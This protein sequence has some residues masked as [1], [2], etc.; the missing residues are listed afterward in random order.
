M[1]AVP[2]FLDRRTLEFLLFEVH[3]AAS[4]CTRDRFVDYDRADF[5]AMLSIARDMSAAQFAPH[6]ARG[7][8]EEPN[9]GDDGTVVLPPEVKP[10]LDAFIEAGFMASTFDAAHGGLQLPYLVTLGY[11]SFFYSAN[12]GT[13]AYAGLTMAAANLLQTFGTP[14][15]QRFTGAMI[16]GRMFG[17][18]CLS[19]PHAG[20]S[21]GNT[22]CKAIPRDDGRYA[23][24]GDKM[25]I[26]GGEHELSENIGHL[27]LARMPDAPAGTRGIS[28]FIVPRY[29]IDED[30][31]S[32][33]VDN[34]VR[35]TGI[36]HK[37]GS[38][39]TINCVMTFG[40][41][42]ES[43]GELVGE[44]NR[45]LKLMFMMMNEARI[46]VGLVAAV[47]GIA[48]HRNS[49]AYA[50]ERPQGHHPDNR[51]ASAP[52]L[53]IIEHA[54][55]RRMLLAQKAYSEGALDL[56]LYCARLVD[57]ELTAETE[58]ERHAAG[59]LLGL[60]TP[61][62]K[63]WP[64]EYC[65]QGN[66]LAIQVLGGYGY[67]RD[68]PVE[69]LYRDNRLNAIHEG[70]TAIQAMDLLGRKIA[71]DGGKALAQLGQLIKATIEEAAS[72]PVL[73]DFIAALGHALNTVKQTTMALMPP[74][75]K[76]DTR[77]FLANATDYLHLLGHVVIAWR[78]LAQAKVA[79]TAL[80]ADPTGKD[81][82]FYEGKLW[83]CRWFYTHALPEIGP[84]AKRLMAL[85]RTTLDAPTY[86]V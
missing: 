62:T 80:V 20:S 57:D 4:L 37:M 85:D 69:R 56:V 36:N 55:V 58:Q 28:L 23:I 52:E 8:A 46:G 35:C 18:M 75:M 11:L 44:P 7:D 17:T 65:T 6:A 83:A 3:D 51:D 33:G 78:W 50:L 40:D 67:T 29:R 72:D 71:R 34:H 68:Y 53:M 22:R 81:S 12:T 38:R 1:S 48:G 31:R 84:R 45:G 42:G 63:A 47:Q 14:A 73:A 77:L 66:S 54:D 61:I 49:K 43:I 39:G 60:L 82:E 16:E 13:A 70:T 9:F 74:A 79:R 25:W 10:A 59:Q 24:A 32:T 86:A 64:S 15:Q 5:E 41:G 21:L 30:G 76:G 27:V 2:L 19:E 26:S